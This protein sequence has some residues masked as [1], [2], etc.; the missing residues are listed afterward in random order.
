MVAR[1]EAF[2]KLMTEPAGIGAGGGSGP[3]ADGFM[4]RGTTGTKGTRTTLPGIKPI[5]LA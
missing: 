4:P 5:F 3:P 2:L 1:R